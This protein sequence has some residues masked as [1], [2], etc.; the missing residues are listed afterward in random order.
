MTT[1]RESIL[2]FWSRLNF[3]TPVAGVG[4]PEEEFVKVGVG[5]SIGPA[6]VEVGVTEFAGVWV[7]VGAEVDVGVPLEV[8][9]EVG[10]A[11][12]V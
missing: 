1:S 3:I 5:V 10:L 4:D 7:V 12:G 6:R 11:V 9:V 2:R 8:V